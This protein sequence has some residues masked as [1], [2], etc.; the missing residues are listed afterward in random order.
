MTNE[1]TQ[2]NP[3]LLLLLA[4]S[5]SNASSPT[6]SIK[7]ETEKSHLYHVYKFV[8]AQRGVEEL[9]D[10]EVEALDQFLKEF[11]PFSSELRETCIKHSASLINKHA[12]NLAKPI[13]VKKTL[14][15]TLIGLEKYLKMFGGKPTGFIPKLLPYLGVT[16]PW[17][18]KSLSNFKENWLNPKKVLLRL[19]SGNFA[20][21]KSNEDFEKIKPLQ[22]LREITKLVNSDPDALVIEPSTPHPE[23]RK[24]V[25]EDL[26]YGYIPPVVA[27]TQDFTVAKAPYEE[28]RPTQETAPIAMPS[29]TEERTDETKDFTP[30]S[31]LPSP[32]PEE[33]AP[34]VVPSMAE[35][36]NYGIKNF[37]PQ[38]EPQSQKQ[39]ETEVK[40]VPSDTRQPSNKFIWFIIIVCLSVFGYKL[41]ESN[42][43]PITEPT[44]SFKHKQ[45]TSPSVKQKQTTPQKSN[46]EKKYKGGWVNPG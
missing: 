4:T 23:N 18:G 8:C 35:E 7:N 27:D 42:V 16:Q 9:D 43:K 33:P 46:L 19:D 15:A 41:W 13:S 34:M 3:L 29:V 2:N 39:E 37:T 25:I 24:P 36:G 11:Y 45:T 10:K 30:P 28:H 31:E 6:S 26:D 20:T 44:T 32:K 17:F 21:K 12:E 40:E 5:P 38:P 22:G 1:F 14:I